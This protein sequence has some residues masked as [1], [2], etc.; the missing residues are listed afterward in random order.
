MRVLIGIDGSE[1]GWEAIYQVTRLLSGTRDD[2]ALFCAPPRVAFRR[3]AAPAG[4]VVERTQQS[5]A[6]SVLDEGL[7]RLPAALRSRTEQIIGQEDP[8]TGLPAAAENWKADLIAVGATGAGGLRGLLLGSVPRSILRSTSIPVFVARKK[9]DKHNDGVYRALVAVD[10]VAENDS[11]SKQLEQFTWPQGAMGRVI[12]VIEPLFGT[13]LPSWLAE[14]TSK[15][16]DDELAQAWVTEY[17][18]EKQHKF[19]EMRAYSAT[20]PAPFAGNP[21]VL[22]E[23]SPAEKIIETAVADDIDLIALGTRDLGAWERFMLGSTA[24][25]LIQHS[26]CSVLVSHRAKQG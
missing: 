15:M 12:H 6:T 11:M 9:H 1:G 5:I 19:E 16:G 3:G 23:G 13:E 20:L 17:A 24:E 14:R 22:L 18:A 2:I 26:P 21:P 8:K 10:V 7:Q 4:N 25:K